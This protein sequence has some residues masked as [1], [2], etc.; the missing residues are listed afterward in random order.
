[1]TKVLLDWDG[2]IY[3]FCGEFFEAIEE[4][5]GIKFSRKEID[6][7]D[8]KSF[9]ERKGHGKDIQKKFFSLLDTYK[10]FYTTNKYLNIVPE[11]VQELEKVPE[12]DITIYTKAFWNKEALSNKT[13]I[14]QEFKDNNKQLFIPEVTIEL[15]KPLEIKEYQK[16]DIIIDDKP[17]LIEECLK[18]GNRV[19]MPLHT[20]NEYLQNQV[21]KVFFVK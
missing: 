9:F 3:D 16:Y 4:H 18:E 6:T 1:M 15:S 19:W 12:A 2:T 10:K 8:F 17:D 14:I 7:Y 13:R 20:Y 11:I 5:F 21:E